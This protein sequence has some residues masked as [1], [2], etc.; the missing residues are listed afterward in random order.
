MNIRI[1][2][3]DFDIGAEVSALKQSGEVGAVVTF[4][5]VVRRDGGIAEM[6]L[7]HYPGMT[8][9]EIARHV[10]EARARW[11][12]TG[13]SIVHRIG[14]LRPGENIV[15]VGV[16]AA[17]RQAA[18]EAAEFLMDYLKTRA[19]FWKRER[20]GAEVAWVEAKASDEAAADRWL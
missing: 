10:D 16:A 19:P 7:E 2:A 18:F 15:L 17:H 3:A 9:R 13:V 8:E 14:T 11:P 4:I 5:G 20:H 1:Q 12:L 6:M